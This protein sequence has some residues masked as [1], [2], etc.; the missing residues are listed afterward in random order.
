M[1]FIQCDCCKGVGKGLYKKIELPIKAILPNH[2]HRLQM[3]KLDV[4][5]DCL[6][7]FS[8]FYYS[9]CEENNYSGIIAIVHELEED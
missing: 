4:C 7:K 8:E 6:R 3:K 9:I 2:E 5:E 1:R